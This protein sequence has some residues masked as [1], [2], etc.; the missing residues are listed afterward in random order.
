ME[1]ARD[2][3]LPPVDALE[4]VDREG[5]PLKVGMRVRPEQPLR[6]RPHEMHLLTLMG[7][8]TSFAYDNCVRVK[9]DHVIHA[10]PPWEGMSHDEDADVRCVVHGFNLIPALGA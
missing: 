10:K 4:A 3:L 9:W 5:R 2:S 7:T 8:I 6:P 1:P